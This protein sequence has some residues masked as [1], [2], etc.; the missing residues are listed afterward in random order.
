MKFGKFF[1]RRYPIVCIVLILT[2]LPALAYTDA[3]DE[4]GNS[5][6]KVA[7][8]M[9]SAILKD[10]AV[11]NVIKEGGTFKTHCVDRGETWE[12]ISASYGVPSKF[13]K[14]LNP[15][16]Q[17]CYAGAELTIPVLPASQEKRQRMISGK[18][19]SHALANQYEEAARAF[20]NKDY[21]KAVKVY[22]KII[23]SHPSAQ[24]Y[25]NRGLAQFNREKWRQASEDLEK[26][27]EM[28]EATTRMKERCE[29]LLKISRH[30][31]EVWVQ[32]RNRVIGGV[33]AGVLVA[34]A[35]TYAA[36]EM[37]KSSSSN[38]TQL[39]TPSFSDSEASANSLANMD[40]NNI[41]SGLMAKTMQDVSMQNM[42]YN[43]TF[44]MLMNRTIQQAHAEKQ[45]F[46]VDFK[47]NNP[48]ASDLDAEN[49][50]TNYL[51]LKYGGGGYSPSGESDYD[52]KT[53]S[54]EERK[55]NILN[56]VA[57][58]Y[59]QACGGSGKCRACGGTKIARGMGL[60]YHC[61]LC[62]ANGD[63][64]VCHGTGKAS[65]NR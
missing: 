27:S 40:M 4:V 31:H 13:L 46:I 19:M 53:A 10:E 30:N 39:F 26:A 43:A 7:D 21:G 29:E 56:H 12:S 24:A 47:A 15:G 16:I 18:K 1:N 9:A 51:S 57:G 58:E 49:A 63:C 17:D 65:W 11:A 28:E 8:I 14:T 54:H 44:D 6:A 25:F 64:P 33:I 52:T 48:Y 60:E 37:S 61:N 23:K 3:S 42:Q 20:G 50:Y 62:N 36:V 34:G 38:T 2:F 5:D 32:N 55:R 41:S 59:C 35:A 22:G 45:N